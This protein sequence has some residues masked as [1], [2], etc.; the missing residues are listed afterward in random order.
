MKFNIVPAGRLWVMVEGGFVAFAT[1]GVSSSCISAGFGLGFVA[2]AT[3]WMSRFTVATP[4]PIAFRRRPFRRFRHIRRGLGD[5]ERWFA[6]FVATGFPSSFVD[7]G[8]GF[9]FATFV[10]DWVMMEGGFDR[11]LSTGVSSSCVRAGSGFGFDRFLS[12]PK[13]LWMV[14]CEPPSAL[15]AAD[16]V[17]VE[18]GFGTF[19]P[20]GF[21]SSFVDAGSGFGFG[22]FMPTSLWSVVCDTPNALAAARSAVFRHV[23]P[24]L[25]DGERWFCPTWNSQLF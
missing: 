10:A 6:T 1:T 18:G 21:P 16:W 13:S 24:G 14:A 22:T 2:F 5:G 3:G 15:A 4:T 25:G 9:D 8:S 19:V 7:A 11:F 23:R 17:M 20:R 12:S